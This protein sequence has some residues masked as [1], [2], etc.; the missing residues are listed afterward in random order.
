VVWV[1]PGTYV[2][3]TSPH[4]MGLAR[5]DGRLNA[6][7]SAGFVSVAVRNKFVGQREF[8]II[9]SQSGQR[10]SQMRLL[11]I[12]IAAP[13]GMSGRL[14]LGTASIASSA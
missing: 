4:T 6:C 13:A 5:G 14:C 1:M 12:P 3:D 11:V 7:P 8:G 2:V 10:K 9:S